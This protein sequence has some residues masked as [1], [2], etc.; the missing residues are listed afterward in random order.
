MVNPW[1]PQQVNKC[2]LCGK[3]PLRI[4]FPQQWSPLRTICSDK[5]LSI[6]RFFSSL[7]FVQFLTDCALPPLPLVLVDIPLTDIFL[8]TCQKQS[9]ATAHVRKFVQINT[10]LRHCLS[11]NRQNEPVSKNRYPQVFCGILYNKFLEEKVLNVKE[12]II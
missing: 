6:K 3:C 10:L 2:S 12:K 11:Q 7:C 4:Y 1:F 8:L 9:L 5:F